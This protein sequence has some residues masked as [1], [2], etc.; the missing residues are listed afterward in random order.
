MQPFGE[1]DTFVVNEVY[2]LLR[3]WVEGSVKLADEILEQY[4]GIERPW[5]FDRVNIKQIVRQTNLEECVESA[6]SGG[7]SG[8]SSSGRSSS[9]SSG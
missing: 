3:G 5:R 7:I 2:S 8:S 6:P 4:F 9:G 1:H